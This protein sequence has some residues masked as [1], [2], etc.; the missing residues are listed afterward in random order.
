[1]NQSVV[2]DWLA[3]LTY[4]QQTVLLTAIRGCDGV[5]KEDISKKFVRKYRSIV[6]KNA[7]PGDG[8]DTFMKTNIGSQEIES[9]VEHL[10][11]YPMHW[12][13][14]F[15]HA[16]EI[17]GYKHPNREIANWSECLYKMIVSALHMRPETEKEMDIRLADAI[18]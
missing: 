15:I 17:V 18:V 8:P 1:M 11:H 4:K 2:Q 5:G 9:F 3:E 13:F 10:D 12:L 7:A 16:V 6:L 14:H